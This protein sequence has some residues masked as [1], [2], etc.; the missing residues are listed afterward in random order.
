[1]W[2]SKG[3]NVTTSVS[4]AVDYWTEHNLSRVVCGDVKPQLHIHDSGYDSSRFDLHCKVGVYRGS[5]KKT[6]EKSKITTVSHDVPMVSVGFICESTTIHGG[7][8]TNAT[9]AYTIQY[10][11]STVAPRC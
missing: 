2:G 3:E 4:V 1:M 10:E 5:K 7:S 9:D 11:A 8:A 6:T